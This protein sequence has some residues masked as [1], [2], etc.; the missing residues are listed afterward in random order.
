MELSKAVRV[1]VVL[2][3]TAGNPS[4]L[5]WLCLKTQRLDSNVFTA[6]RQVKIQSEAF[7]GNSILDSSSGPPLLFCCSSV[8]NFS[9]QWEHSIKT[10]FQDRRPPLTFRICPLTPSPLSRSWPAP[11]H[12][13]QRSHP[14]CQQGESLCRKARVPPQLLGELGNLMGGLRHPEEATQLAAAQKLVLMTWHPATQHRRSQKPERQAK[15][16]VSCTTL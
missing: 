11:P 1:L 12:P 4:F 13:R 3:S 6:G 15:F 8:E 14:P 10:A 5:W 2:V 7:Q 16:Q 9:P